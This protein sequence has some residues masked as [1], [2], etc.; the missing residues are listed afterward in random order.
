[1]HIDLKSILWALLL[2]ATL[3]KLI[4]ISVSD[5][6]PGAYRDLLSV[7]LVSGSL[8]LV[9]SLMLWILPAQLSMAVLMLTSVFALIPNITSG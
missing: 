6:S 7:Y 9:A 4:Y 8:Y 1:M 3:V 5:D 2:V